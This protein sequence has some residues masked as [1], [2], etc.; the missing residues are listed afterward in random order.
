MLSFETAHFSLRDA[1]H[2][3]FGKSLEGLVVKIVDSSEEKFDVKVEVVAETDGDIKRGEI[4]YVY[5]DELVS[6]EDAYAI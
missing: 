6:V 5:K 2:R 1:G 3:N 4:L